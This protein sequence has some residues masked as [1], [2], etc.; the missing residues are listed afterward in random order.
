M[1][2]V[3]QV[4]GFPVSILHPCDERIPVAMIGAKDVPD[5]IQFWIIDDSA[6]PSDR[7]FRDAWELDV[8]AMGDP[9]GAGDTV[10][11]NAWYEENRSTFEDGNSDR[12]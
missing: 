1:K 4:E 7:T 9:D 11:F 5:G 3:Y 10:A 8:E 12:N 6:I 2:I